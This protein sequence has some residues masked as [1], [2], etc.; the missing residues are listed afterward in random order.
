M[1]RHKIDQQGLRPLQDKLEATT[2]I[3]TPKNENEIKFFLG[4][5]Q[6]H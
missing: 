6:Y 1:D 2:K 4:S 3:N 5:I